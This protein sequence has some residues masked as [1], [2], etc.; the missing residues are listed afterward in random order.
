[1]GRRR[2]MF[3]WTDIDEDD[4]ANMFIVK[5]L[6][7]TKLHIQ[8]QNH[9]YIILV[10]DKEHVFTCTRV[11]LLVLFLFTIFFFFIFKFK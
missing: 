1:V 8:W 7:W 2:N 5:S 11:I 4:D 6:E 10:L 3:G 9:N